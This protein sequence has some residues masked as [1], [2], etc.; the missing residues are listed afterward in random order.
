MFAN[1]RSR[2]P[3]LTV[4]RTRSGEG[5]AT[6]T[7]ATEATCES[8]ADCRRLSF[9]AAAVG[10]ACDASTRRCACT[11]RTLVLTRRGTCLP[12][13]EKGIH[14]EQRTYVLCSVLKLVELGDI[15]RPRQQFVLPNLATQSGDSVRV[16]SVQT[17]AHE[18]E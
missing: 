17:A 13:G 18:K 14:S 10:I 3:S 16:T 9:Q 2:P 12:R 6:T 5:D 11:N 15:K 4:G 7:S 1:P 8:D